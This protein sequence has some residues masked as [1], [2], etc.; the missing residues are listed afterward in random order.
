MHIP[1]LLRP[2][3]FPRSPIG[4]HRSTRPPPPLDGPIESKW[5][6]NSAFVAPAP[7]RHSIHSRTRPDSVPGHS[8]TPST[9]PNVPAGHW[10]RLS[11]LSGI[12][13]GDCEAQLNPGASKFSGAASAAVVYRP[14]A[15]AASPAR[16]PRI[17]THAFLL[18]QLFLHLGVQPRPFLTVLSLALRYPSQSS[19]MKFIN[20]L[21]YRVSFVR[22]P[23][24][25]VSG[26]RVQ[27][28]HLSIPVSPRGKAYDL[29]QRT[30]DADAAPDARPAAELSQ[31]TLKTTLGLHFHKLLNSVLDGF[32]TDLAQVVSNSFQPVLVTDVPQLETKDLPILIQRFMAAN[33][34][35]PGFKQGATFI[36]NATRNAETITLYTI[37]E[38]KGLQ[39]S[40]ASNFLLR[41][42][43]ISA[44][45]REGLAS[46][47]Q[48]WHDLESTLSR[49]RLIAMHDTRSELTLLIRFPS[50]CST[51][52]EGA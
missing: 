21:S 28:R 36:R 19:T 37:V 8:D 27:V 38:S 41:A 44:C 32:V 33:I 49:A 1:C 14:D 46:Y 43:G 7:A 40:V 52:L 22:S 15:P 50:Q 42:L 3:D 18:L 47:H 48:N 30:K 31:F 11:E 45:D 17:Y 26:L 23:T 20:N 39:T 24:D 5:H 2:C 13:C 51:E 35:A 4:R 12:L 25:V 6:E 9:S 29:V 34:Q 10:R 16:S